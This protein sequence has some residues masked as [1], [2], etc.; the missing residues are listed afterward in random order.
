NSLTLLPGTRIYHMG[1]AAGFT[2]EGSKITLASYVHYQ[3]TA[4]NLTLA[5]Y[6]L[7]AVPQFWLKRVLAKDYGKRTVEMKQYPRLGG[8]VI[9]LGMLK[10]VVHSLA[11]RDISPIP[12]PLDLVF[13]RLFV[14]HKGRKDG[15]YN[16]PRGFE[17]SLPKLAPSRPER[18][19]KAA[20]KA[21]AAADFPVLQ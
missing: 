1:E 21:A 15:N 6:N 9:W 4:L 12:R 10:K 8:I 7:T 19:Q 3:P 17:S 14:R 16:V 18:I 11:R 13:G 2:D 5:F 20:A